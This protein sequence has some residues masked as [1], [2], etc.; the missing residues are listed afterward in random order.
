MTTPET[1]VFVPKGSNPLLGAV[2]LPRGRAQV[3]A[4][5]YREA[6]LD[7]LQ[8]LL[9]KPPL[10]SIQDVLTLYVANVENLIE[11][12]R[13]LWSNLLL[14]TEEIGTMY[15][16]AKGDREFPAPRKSSEEGQKA[17]ARQNLLEMFHAGGLRPQ[18][19][20]LQRLN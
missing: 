10:R 8:L 3:T 1:L 9:E 16:L 17:L 6:W 4:Q 12:P 19:H 15:S 7:R 11:Q 13:E 5:E 2:Y 20:R 14:E 18:K